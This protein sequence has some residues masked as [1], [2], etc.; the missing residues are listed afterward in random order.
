MSTGIFDRADYELRFQS[1]HDVGRA[2]AFPCDADGRVNMDAL[3]R[4]ALNNYL[5]ARAFIG[6]EF[7]VPCVRNIDRATA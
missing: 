4:A 6:R 7:N 3:G 5:Y 2:M 1:L